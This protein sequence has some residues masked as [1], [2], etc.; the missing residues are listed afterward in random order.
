MAVM[1]MRACIEACES[2]RQACLDC[3]AKCR[4]MGHVE[5]AEL[6]HACHLQGERCLAAMRKGSHEECATCATIYA[7]CAR[8]C[9]TIDEETHRICAD[10]CARCAD[11]CG[12]MAVAA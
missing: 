4:E 7:D 10:E 9:A 12:K 3:E 5:M 8:E 11:E 1:D 2:C 6:C